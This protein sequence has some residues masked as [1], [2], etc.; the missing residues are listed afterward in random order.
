MSA[1]PYTPD[2]LAA[3]WGCSGETVRLL[4][5]SGKL[6]AFRVGTND[7]LGVDGDYRAAGDTGAPAAAG[8][9]M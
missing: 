9:V 4:C 6:P 8:Y 3:R 2:T 1:L 5:A 7:R